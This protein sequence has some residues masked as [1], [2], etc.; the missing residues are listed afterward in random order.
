MCFC[1]FCLVGIYRYVVL[2]AKLKVMSMF[3]KLCLPLLFYFYGF[4]KLY[5]DLLLLHLIVNENLRKGC[6]LTFRQ[7]LSCFDSGLYFTQMLALFIGY[8][9]MLINLILLGDHLVAG[10]GWTTF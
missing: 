10:G 9:S 6:V 5:C 3:Y 8:I 4:G 7:L 1:I 2:C